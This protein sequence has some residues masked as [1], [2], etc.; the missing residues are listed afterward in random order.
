MSF[1]DSEIV[2]AEIANIQE[3][4]QEIYA[5]SSHYAM[6]SVQQKIDHIDKMNSLLEKQR[7]LHTRIKLSDDEEAKEIIEKM[8][9]A[10]SAI[11]VPTDVSFDQLFDQ[12]ETLLVS[13]RKNVMRSA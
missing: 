1:F 6:M 5:E 9:K 11:G 10:A 3:I 4:Q 7:I 2:R 12:M 8:K 13:M